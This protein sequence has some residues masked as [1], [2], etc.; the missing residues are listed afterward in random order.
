MSRTHLR[1]FS[2]A[3]VAALSVSS[4]S[5]VAMDST[6]V[7]PESINSPSIRM[8]IVSGIGMKFMSSGDLM[9]LGDYNSIE[10]DAKALAQFEPR[11][12]QLV[13]VLNQF[14]P[15]RLG[16]ELSLG[17]LRVETVP[18]VR[19]FAPVYAR[20]MTERWTLGFG[21]PI[22]TYKNKLSLTQTGS[23]LDAIRAQLGNASPTLSEAFEQLNVNL[24]TTAHELLAKKGYRPLTDRDETQ[25]G[26]LQLVSILQFAKREKSSAQF[27]T[28]LSLPTGQGNDPDDL[29]D[30]GTFGYLAIENQILGNYVIRNR[31][32]L[33]AK[34]GFRYTFN[35][36]VMRRVPLNEEDTLPDQNTKEQ[37]SRQTGLAFFA[38]GSLTYAATDTVDLAIGVES[39]RKAADSYSGKLSNRYDLLGRD[40]ESSS[41]RL[42]MGVTYSSVEK[43]L[44]G[45]A[46]LPTMIAYEFSDTI[47]GLNTERMTV[48]EIW[49]Q[50]FF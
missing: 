48:H 18:E 38:G 23:N 39:T 11:V 50:L 35:D 5:A 4:G 27:K 43:F 26:D 14:G 15:Q 1:V 20:G 42:R 36:R 9:T 44:A 28:I 13:A 17:V 45:Q 21:V 12:N 8:G 3:V 33:A 32:Q 34:G 31:W 6:Q 24:A 29:A 49:L 41:D 7:L 10:F 2:L 25:V 37:V 47:R 30:L 22:L 19:Y 16:D 40:T 46:W